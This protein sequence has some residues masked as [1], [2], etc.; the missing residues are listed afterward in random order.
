[1]V[2]DLRH[3]PLAYE[4]NIILYLKKKKKEVMG[5]ISIMLMNTYQVALKSFNLIEGKEKS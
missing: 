4:G 1:M 2:S 3:I 5:S